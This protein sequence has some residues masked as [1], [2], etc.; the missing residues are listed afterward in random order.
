MPAPDRL[1]VVSTWTD[2]SQ[3]GFR[4]LSQQ[5]RGAYARAI[6]ITSTVTRQDST[7]QAHSV[8]VSGM[9]QA[10]S[11]WLLARDEE[12]GE[13][14]PAT[15]PPNGGAGRVQTR[16]VASIAEGS[17][18]RP[19]RSRSLSPEQRSLPA[20]GAGSSSEGAYVIALSLGL[21]RGEILDSPGTTRAAEGT[22]VLH[23]RRQLIRDKS[24]VQCRPQDCGS[25]R[26]ALSRPVVAVLERHRTRQEAEE[27]VVGQRWNNEHE[28][29]FTSNVGT[30]LDPEAFGRTVPKI[31]KEAG[32]GIGRFM[33]YAIRALR[34]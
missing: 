32:L 17:K 7:Q 1:T 2:G 22:V 10:S 21:R 19:R 34:S 16:N 24:G 23:V 20:G 28:L 4:A 8:D 31:C 27:L 12:N 29:I 9:L 26:T 18:T 13:G 15:S 33:S 11:A 30:P 6:M 5:G 3:T 14:N 25:R